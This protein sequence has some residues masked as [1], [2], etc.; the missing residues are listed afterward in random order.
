MN[1]KEIKPARMAGAGDTTRLLLATRLEAMGDGV[2]D[3]L[4]APPQLTMQEMQATK[5]HAP[6]KV[7]AVKQAMKSGQTLDQMAHRFRHMGRGY[8]RRT[9][10]DIR[11][12][13]SEANTHT[14]HAKISAI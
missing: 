12:A 13:L 11:A 9:L 10:A 4:A 3:I 6:A 2:F 7:L 1:W 14:K 5:K 8:S